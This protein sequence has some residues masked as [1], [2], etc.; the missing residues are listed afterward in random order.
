MAW[1]APPAAQGSVGEFSRRFQGPQRGNAHPGPARRRAILSAMA[2]AHDEREALRMLAGSP[3]GS[4]ESIMLTHG[5]AIG[6]LH[7]LVR[8][9]LATAERRTMRAGRRL[10]KVTWMT[11]TDAGRQALAE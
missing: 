2:I 10:I 6:T 4:T 11:I 3:N 1:P 7:G 8:N 5:F 9:G